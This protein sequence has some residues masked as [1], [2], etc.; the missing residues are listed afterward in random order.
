MPLAQFHAK[1]K[2]ISILFDNLPIMVYI[3]YRQGEK[4]DNKTQN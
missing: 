3:Y 1:Q 4:N 2:K